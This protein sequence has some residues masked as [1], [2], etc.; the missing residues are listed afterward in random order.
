MFESWNIG[1][2]NKMWNQDLIDVSF[3]IVIK[4]LDIQIVYFLV[5]FLK[6][7]LI[8]WLFCIFILVVLNYMFFYWWDII[9]LCYF[10]ILIIDCLVFQIIL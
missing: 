8:K 5:I 1:K 3:I 7:F 10:G 2:Q 4:Q 6:C 9:E